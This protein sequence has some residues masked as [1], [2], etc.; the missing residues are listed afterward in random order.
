MDMLRLVAKILIFVAAIVWTGDIT[1]AA[2]GQDS[3]WRIAGQV[4]G[5]TSALAMR[6]N[7]AYAAEGFRLVVYD[8]ADSSLPHETGSTPAFS[9]FVAAVVVDG[10]QAYVAAGSAGLQ[11]VDISDPATPTVIGVWDSPGCVENVTVLGAIAYVADGPH[12][13]EILDVS[14]PSRPKWISSLFDM[15]YAFD[16][17]VSGRYA[18]VAAAG[19]GLLV[20]DVGDVRAPREIAM[21]D[22]PGYARGIAVAGSTV[23]IAD[24]WGGVRA[25]LVA[26]PAHPLEIGSIALPSWAFDVVVSESNLFVADG[27]QGLRVLDISDP[28]YLRE[29]GSYAIRWQHSGAVAIAGERA[30][31]AARGDGMHVVDVSEA[32]KPKGLASTGAFA[33]ALSILASGDYAFVGAGAQGLRVIDLA[34]GMRQVAAFPIPGG[35]ANSVAA[36]GSQHIVVGSSG[37]ETGRGLY[38]MDVTDPLN[39]KNVSIAFVP[40]VI[41]VAAQGSLVAI[42]DELGLYLVDVSDPA[43]PARASYLDFMG[44]DP[45]ASPTGGVALVNQIACVAQSGSGL[46]LVDL[47][48]PRNPAIIGTYKPQGFNQAKAVAAAGSYA[49][50]LEFPGLLHIVDISLPHSPRTVAILQLPGGS[51]ERVRLS[52]TTLVI[53]MGSGGLAT[54]DVSNPTKPAITGSLRLPG[55]AFSAAAAGERVL[56]AAGEAGVFL[57]GKSTTGLAPTRMPAGLFVPDLS[58]PQI[59]IGAATR[60]ALRLVTVGQTDQAGRLEKECG[61]ADTPRS[62]LTRTMADAGGRTLTIT[63]SADSGTGTLR[64]ALAA[65]EE[66]D[67]VLFDPVVFPPKAPSTIRPTSP[68]PCLCR[69]R[70]T[71]DASNAGV[72]LDGSAA[73]PGTMGL[74]ITSSGNK[75]RGLQILNFSHTGMFVSGSDNLIGGERSRGSGPSGEGNVLSGN[76]YSGINFPSTTASRNRVVGNFIGTDATG[77]RVLGRQN[78]GVFVFPGGPGN[79]I[80]GSQPWEANIISGNVVSEVFLQQGQSTVIIGNLIGT[81]PAGTKRVGNGMAGVSTAGHT[82]D[83]LISGNI[84]VGKQQGVIV[85]DSGS[86]YNQ[87]VGNRIGVGRDGKA[88]A[89][90]GDTSSNGVAL[91]QS[92]TRVADNAIGGIPGWGITLGFWGARE[93]FIT[94]NLIGTDPSG[95]TA[96]PNGSPSWGGGVLLTAASRTFLGGTTSA[97]RNV[98]SGNRG[99]GVRILGPGVYDTFIIGNLIGTD[100]G[101]SARLGNSRYGINL[102]SAVRTQIQGNIIAAN[103]SWGAAISDTTSSRFRRNSIYANT[104]GGINQSPDSQDVGSAPAIFSVGSKGV[105][106]TACTDCTVELFS[107][108]AGQ[109]RIYEGSAIANALGRF[110]FAKP[111]TLAGPYLTATATAAEGSTSVFSAAARIAPDVTTDAPGNLA[112]YAVKLNGTVNPFGLAATACFQWGNSTSYG[113]ATAPQTVGS[114]SVGL[115]VSAG[116][117]GLLPNTT[118]HY[119]IAVTNAAGTYY[120]SDVSFKTL[121]AD[122]S[123]LNLSISPGGASIASTLGDNG[124][125]QTGY[126]AVEV[127]SGSAPYGTAVFSM[128]QNGVVVSEVAVPA[129]PPTRSALIFI[130]YRMDVWTGSGPAGPATV[131]INTG[132]AV[133]NL[134][135]AA[136]NILCKLRDSGGVM[137]A[138]AHGTI[139]KNAHEALFIDELNRIAPDFSLPPG[140]ATGAGFAS[141]ELASDQPLSVVAMRMTVNERG[142]PLMTTTPVADL[143][144]PPTASSAFF[145][146]FADGGGYRTS[147]FLLNTSGQLEEGTVR[148]YGNNGSPLAV[149][150]IGDQGGPS[151]VFRYSIKP[152][153]FVA[154]ISDGSSDTLSSGSVQVTPDAG[155]Y[156]PVGAGLFSCAPAGTLITESG[157]PSTVPT[158]HARIYIDRSNGH[159]TGLAIASTGG[160]PVHVTLRALGMD[161]VTPAGEG[162]LNLSAN[163]HDAKFDYQFIDSLPIGFTGVMDISSPVPF[164][165]LTL[166][167]LINERG[168]FLLT[169]FPVSDFN[170]TA[171]VPIVFP[172]IADGGGIK[173]EFIFLSAGGAVTTTLSFY[174]NEGL[175]LPVGRIQ[176]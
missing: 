31:V 87:I 84:I 55:Y 157:I 128:K 92:F 20:A 34:A 103:A 111:G 10:S 61:G 52:G 37:I 18:F 120:G 67:T 7:Y 155:N 90:G 2:P 65:V 12:G 172:Q 25:I 71:I 140:F 24:Q 54:V 72:I 23:F 166:R 141:L 161:G 51:V 81:D 144:K 114:G 175:Y 125:L 48:D 138:T 97:E 143:L 153:G 58:L 46:R 41:D 16:V 104:S 9:D 83:N 47:S 107:D 53:A 78:V 45:L 62:R 162:E 80:G 29:T 170:Q 167:S 95:M 70:V 66:G 176:P 5:P 113:H 100:S 105:S 108:D 42:T 165:A 145:P 11:V 149:H 126:A 137:L 169:T 110:T 91:S 115:S 86:F 89:A 77:T 154:M 33:N 35:Y 131:D 142:E 63:S 26:E 36:I 96:V 79:V 21:L 147:L 38:I 50:L 116:L 74:L 94:G 160:L 82:F 56:V 49:Y 28:S 93:S 39:P 43:A 88:L 129:S 102:T 4:G 122:V 3:N 99:D 134:G 123:R 13:L 60:A 132:L 32:A 152:G 59:S 121:C 159:S 40:G 156:A 68:L 44:S 163:G 17:A 76:T 98:I 135:N 158:T 171:P 150:L 14:D 130:D 118:Y 1:V 151:D 30:C 124:P 112:P 8:L 146:Q 15:Q 133:V 27:S 57:A 19:A 101:G 73:P 139:E 75:I 173:T 168:E 22:T 109:G 69:D 127:A 106:G 148:L 6:G 85:S 117:T 164:A 174:D 119:R 136:A 64:E